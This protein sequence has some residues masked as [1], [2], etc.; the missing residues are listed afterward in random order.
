MITV[1][2]PASDKVRRPPMAEDIDVLEKDQ[3]TGLRAWHERAGIDQALTK[4]STAERQRVMNIC[5]DLGS[6]QNAHRAV[7]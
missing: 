1:G 4:H 7:F 2:L 5:R 3:R 6:G